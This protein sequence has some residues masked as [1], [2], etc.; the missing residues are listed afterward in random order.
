MNQKQFLWLTC[1]V[2]TIL[3]FQNCS[4]S[5][6]SSQSQNGGASRSIASISG[7][8]QSNGATVGHVLG[9]YNNVASMYVPTIDSYVNVDLATGEYANDFAYFSELNC[10]GVPMA[11]SHLGTSNKAVIFVGGRYYRVLEKFT[12]TFIYKSWNTQGQCSNISPAG[13]VLSNPA[14]RVQ[15]INRPYDF[16]SLAPLAVRFK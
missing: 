15:E 13:S 4:R 7:Y 14:Y 5:S 16:E 2:F 6:D 1:A 3:G 10:T 11:T 12:G 8:V 9:I